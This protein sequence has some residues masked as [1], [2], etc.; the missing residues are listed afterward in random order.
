MWKEKFKETKNENERRRLM[1]SAKRSY[2]RVILRYLSNRVYSFSDGSYEI[3]FCYPGQKEPKIT[4]K[5]RLKAMEKIRKYKW[6]EYSDQ[7][8]FNLCTILDFLRVRK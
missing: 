1:R 4:D 2:K 5:T 6:D 8:L 3:N 7:S